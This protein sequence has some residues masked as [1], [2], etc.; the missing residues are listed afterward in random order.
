MLFKYIVY[1][2]IQNSRH[3]ATTDVVLLQNLEIGL[4]CLVDI[5]A[6]VKTTKFY[7]IFSALFIAVGY[8]PAQA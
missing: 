8:I 2:N 1:S 7:S 3:V 5:L 6:E 4:L